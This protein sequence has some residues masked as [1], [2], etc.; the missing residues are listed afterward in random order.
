[1]SIPTATTS[2]SAAIVAGIAL[3]LYNGWP[4]FKLWLAAGVCIA[5]WRVRQS[6]SYR[7]GSRKGPAAPTM[8]SADERV[9]TTHIDWRKIHSVSCSTTYLHVPTG[10]FVPQPQVHRTRR[11]LTVEDGRS[12]CPTD[13]AVMVARVQ[14]ESVGGSVKRQSPCQT[15]CGCVRFERSEDSPQW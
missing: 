2:F 11:S 10:T 5:N 12:P 4:P 9:Y 1:M 7:A 8:D 13:V 15:S 3:H 6:K 14:H